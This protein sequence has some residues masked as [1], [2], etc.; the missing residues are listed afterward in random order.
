MSEAEL[1]AKKV[2]PELLDTW[3]RGVSLSSLLTKKDTSGGNSID[4]GEDATGPTIVRSETG[5]PTTRSLARNQ[6]IVDQPVFLNENI[7]PTQMKQLLN[8][9]YAPELV[10]ANVGAFR[11]KVDDIVVDK[12]L[13]GLSATQHSN[14]ALAAATKAM[15]S[16]L[17]AKMLSIPGVRH[18]DLLWILSPAAQATIGDLFS[19]VVPATLLDSA[20]FGKIKGRSINGTPA[21]S[22]AGIPGYLRRRKAISA[23]AIT[24]GDTL[25][26]TMEDADHDFVV[27][28]R[29]RTSGLTVDTGDVGAATVASVSGVTVTFVD[30]DFTDAADNGEGFLE[31]DSAMALLIARSRCFF[32]ADREV[33]ESSITKR[34]D[35]A[36]WVHQMFDNIGVKCRSGAVRAVHFELVEA[37]D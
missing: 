8:G 14:L 18:E 33:P 25:T 27:G 10:R 24:G 11:N 21:I 31:T 32:G 9:N 26:L 2:D 35:A 17:E 23:S 4:I 15:L 34:T 13:L 3:S 5:N 29:A 6:L 19:D 7:S 1:A 20:D 36:G 30:A 16:R 37:E 28:Q 22:H 12:M